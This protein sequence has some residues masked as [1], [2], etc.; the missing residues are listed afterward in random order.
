M[1][2]QPG[3]LY[4][5]N[6][7]KAGIPVDEQTF[8]PLQTTC[9]TCGENLV[10]TGEQVE[11][12]LA[13]VRLVHWLQAKH[14]FNFNAVG[15]IILKR[16]AK[17]IQMPS[18]EM[19]P[20][21]EPTVKA[22]I[23]WRP[24]IA[25]TRRDYGLTWKEFMA[26]HTGLLVAPQVEAIASGLAQPMDVERIT[27]SNLSGLRKQIRVTQLPGEGDIDSLLVELELSW[28]VPMADH[29]AAKGAG[30]SDEN[31]TAIRSTLAECGVLADTV[32]QVMTLLGKKAAS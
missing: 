4:C 2:I 30:I 18:I 14:R 5:P 7:L 22:V 9:F 10:K 6:C 13:A 29:I 31:A 3:Y 19:A 11:T 1:L 15:T 25:G 17:T 32:E 21:S 26:K 27:W 16:G 28:N 24:F 12:P 20:C 23:T 8:K